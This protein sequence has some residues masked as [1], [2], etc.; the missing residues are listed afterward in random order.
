MRKR[1]ARIRRP[2]PRRLNRNKLVKLKL[3]SFLKGRSRIEIAFAVVLGVWLLLT[4]LHV[5]PG[6]AALF[7]FAAFVLGAVLL[8][9]LVRYVARQSIWRLR[10]RL[11]VTYLFIGVVPVVLILILCAIGGYIVAGQVAV[12]LLS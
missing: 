8:F 9:R 4:N 2:S 11:I 1:A 5:L 10:N 7:G 12:F 6:L 3:A